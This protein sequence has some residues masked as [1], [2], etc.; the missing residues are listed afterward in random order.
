MKS[1]LIS[2]QAIS[3]SRESLARTLIEVAGARHLTPILSMEDGPERAKSLRSLEAK[4]R[5]KLGT[6]PKSKAK[7]LRTRNAG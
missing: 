1:G 2:S 4:L 5:A 3:R 6:P 7:K